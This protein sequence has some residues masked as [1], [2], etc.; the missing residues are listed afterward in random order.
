MKKIL[1]IL[2][3][4]GLSF[5]KCIS[6]EVSDAEMLRNNLS[7]Q[8]V[9]THTLKNL[10]INDPSSDDSKALVM[11]H[12]DFKFYHHINIKYVQSHLPHMV[13]VVKPNMVFEVIPIQLNA[14]TQEDKDRLYSSEYFPEKIKNSTDN[15]FLYFFIFEKLPFKYNHLSL[16]DQVKLFYKNHNVI[17]VT[18]KKKP[19]MSLTVFTKEMEESIYRQYM[20]ST[21]HWPSDI[22]I[23]TYPHLRF[24]SIPFLTC[25][26]CGSA[27]AQLLCVYFDIEQDKYLEMAAKQGHEE[28]LYKCGCVYYND[29]QKAF[30]YLKQAADKGHVLAA[31]KCGLMLY[32]GKFLEINFSEAFKYFE[33]AAKWYHK[34]AL[35]YCGMILK[36]GDAT[37]DEGIKKDLKRALQYFV[38]A[39]KYRHEKALSEYH[40]LFAKLIDLQRNNGIYINEANYHLD[41]PNPNFE[42][43]FEL[44]KKA[45]DNYEGEAAVKCGI[46]LMNGQGVGINL[47]EAFNYFDMALKW[48]EAAAYY[49]YGLFL[50]KGVL[51]E[52]DPKGAFYHFA[53]SAEREFAEAQYHYGMLLKEGDT[54]QKVGFRKNEALALEYFERA[55]RQGHEKA[56][57]ERWL[58]CE[59]KEEDEEKKEVPALQQVSLLTSAVWNW[60]TG[61]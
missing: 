23:Q 18:A 8:K 36:E 38:L 45:A 22:F 52:R 1:H 34:N 21:Y 17:Y 30:D 48:D 56:Q 40:S 58:M 35:Y 3:I 14:L 13:S 9:Y 6:T 61:A 43:A 20:R 16:S 7:F 31:F 57:E 28:A 10:D 27:E 24:C 25:A 4:V 60:V 47:P 39:I 49:Y 2:F 26:D 42:E 32:D 54:T 37:K 46:M 53:E 12:M 50:E 15:L 19:N 29:P 41:R 51:G 11:E 55:A 59:K 33:K 5:S 44:F